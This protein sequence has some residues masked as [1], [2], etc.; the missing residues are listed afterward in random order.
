MMDPMA[1][2]VYICVCVS[3]LK[4]GGQEGAA[5]RPRPAIVVWR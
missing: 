1:R 4:V 5:R 3:V 2:H